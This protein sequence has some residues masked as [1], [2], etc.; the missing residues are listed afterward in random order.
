MK[1]YSLFSM[2]NRVGLP[3]DYYMNLQK[4]GTMREKFV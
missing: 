3:L 2:L 4:I 1:L